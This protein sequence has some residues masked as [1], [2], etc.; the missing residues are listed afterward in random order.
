V[1]VNPSATASLARVVPFVTFVKVTVAFAAKPVPVTV[2]VVAIGTA[3][4]TRPVG[5]T[6]ANVGSALTTMA[7]ATVSVPPSS[8]I[9]ML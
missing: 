2:T 1:L 7:P 8:V 9:V 4:S 3:R 6:E 5:L